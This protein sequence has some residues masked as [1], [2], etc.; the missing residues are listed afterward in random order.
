MRQ[1]PLFEMCERI[2]ARFSRREND[3]GERVYVQAFQDYV[4]DYCRTHT[5]DL[6]SFLAW[7]DDNEDKLSV[8]TPQEQDAMRVMTIHKSK[9]LEFKVVIIPFCNWKLD[10][11]TDKTNFLFAARRANPSRKYR[12][13]RC[14]IAAGWRRPITPPSISTKRCTPISITST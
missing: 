10:H 3:R 13:C 9:G 4:L 8:T 6:A 2:I 11:R 12:C 14:G 1:E 7:W 5:A